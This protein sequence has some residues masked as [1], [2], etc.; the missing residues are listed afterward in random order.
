VEQKLFSFQSNFTKFSILQV[1]MSDDPQQRQ[2][3]IEI[4]NLL[5]TIV[6]QVMN[7]SE[8]KNAIIKK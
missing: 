7:N 1:K 3:Y 4:F 8:I 2:K 5:T 6:Q